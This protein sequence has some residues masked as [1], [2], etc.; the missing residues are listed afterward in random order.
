MPAIRRNFTAV[1]HDVIFALRA[2]GYSTPRIAE[3]IGR[4]AISVERHLGRLKRAG[5]PFPF[6]TTGPYNAPVRAVDDPVEGEAWIDVPS[7]GLSLSS[8]GRVKSLKTGLL[9]RPY[10]QQAN[11]KPAVNYEVPGRKSGVTVERL[12]RAALAVARQGPDAQSAALPRR[13]LRSSAYLA[14]E[15]L[16]IC[17]SPTVQIAHARLPGRTVSSL[18]RRAKRLGVSF[19]APSVKW[20]L[21]PPGSAPL[22]VAD[23]AWAEVAVPAR[24]DPD[25]RRDL[26]GMIVQMQLDGFRG[27][28]DEAFQTALRLHRRAFATAWAI[29]LDASIRGADGLRL[30]DTIAAPDEP[31]EPD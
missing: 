13:R 23:I 2:F 8:K 17:R 31:S 7:F 18:Y 3:I 29:S 22:G 12:A 14:H 20:E 6:K 4:S 16:I 28:P 15:D 30:I 11:G 25:F 21:R 5:A 1:E 9:R 19:G 27:S 26:V 24:L 10:Y